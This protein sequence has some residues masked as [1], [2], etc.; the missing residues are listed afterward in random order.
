MKLDFF[1][2]SKLDVVYL[3]PFLS[4]LPFAKFWKQN[5]MYRNGSVTLHINIIKDAGLPK[6]TTDGRVLCVETTVED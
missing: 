4:F 6:Q 3:R 2:F 1:S 5:F